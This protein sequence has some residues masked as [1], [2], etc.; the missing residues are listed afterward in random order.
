MQII[1]HTTY[2]DTLLANFASVP[3]LAQ[4]LN[5]P[6]QSHIAGHLSDGT[7]L[8]PG[9]GPGGNNPANLTA[10]TEIITPNTK[11]KRPIGGSG[12]NA[13]NLI[14]SVAGPSGG[15]NSG[16]D[17]SKGSEVNT[18]AQAAPPTV[19]KRK[20]P[21]QGAQVKAKNQANNANATMPISSFAAVDDGEDKKS[22]V[23]KRATKDDEDGGDQAGNGRARPARSRGTNVRGSGSDEEEEDSEGDSN[24][25]GASSRPARVA[26]APRPVHDAEAATL[27]PHTTIGEDADERRYCFCNNVSYGDMIGCDDDDCEREWVS[28]H[29][30]DC[31]ESSIDVQASLAVPPRLCWSAQ[32]TARN[33]VLR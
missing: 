15:V 32:T 13:N 24:T 10:F 26:R 18:H 4:L 17:K 16:I 28:T 27:V 20:P 7:P 23:K 22:A 21:G 3:S 25:G 31:A 11:R 33:L 2:I 1:S 29:Q 8:A 12:Q 6:V 14:G 19:K 5:P 9:S 30:Q